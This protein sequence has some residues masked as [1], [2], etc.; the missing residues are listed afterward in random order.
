MTDPL[1]NLAQGGTG[2]DRPAGTIRRQLV[3][4][5]VRAWTD[6]LIDLSGRNGLLFYRDLPVGTLD[7]A[8][9]DPSYAE[10]LV[11]GE[12]VRLS[13]LFSADALK[14]AAKRA[15]KIRD[16]AR[17]N[18][19]ERGVDTLYLVRGMATWTPPAG[20]SAVPNAPILLAGLSLTPRGAA[21]ED[22]DLVVDAEVAV[23]PTLLYSLDAN[24]GVKVSLG[25]LAAGQADPDEGDGRLAGPAALY[26]QLEALAGAVPGFEVADRLVVGNF[27]YTKLPMVTDLQAH[28]DALAAHDLVAAIAGDRAAQTAIRSRQVSVD[29]RELDSIKLSDEFLVR[30]A[31]ASQQAAIQA[32]MA[33]SDVVIQGPPGTGKSQ[34]IANLVASLAASGRRVLFVAEKRAAIDAVIGRLDH[35]GLSDLVLDLHGGVKSRRRLAENLAEALGA[36]REAPIP[37]TEDLHYQLAARRKTLRAHDRAMNERRAP[38]GAS[39]YEA[40]ARSVG[41]DVGIR[42]APSVVETLTADRLREIKEVLRQ[43]LALGGTRIRAET[44]PWLAVGPVDQPAVEQLSD[45]VHELDRSAGPELIAAVE[46][47]RTALGT[48]QPASVQD[49]LRQITL[50][51]EL[52]KIACRLDGRRIATIAALAD[53]LEPARRGRVARFVARLTSSPYRHAL[54]SARIAVGGAPVSAEELADLAVTAAQLA[55]RWRS[56]G[57]DPASPVPVSDQGGTQAAAAFQPVMRRIAAAIPIPGPEQLSLAEM[58]SLVRG[59]VEDLPTLRRLPEIRLNQKALESAGLQSFVS[60]VKSVDLDGEAAVAALDVVWAASVIERVVARDPAIGAFDGGRLRDEAAR[61]RVLDRDHVAAAAARVKRAWA[62][63]AVAA[64]DKHED[65]NLVVSA[66]ARKKSGHLAIRD[67]FAQAPD[68]LTAVKPCWAMS[69]L[70][71]SQ[72]LPAGRAYF[73]VVIFDEASQI[74]PA[75]AIASIVRATRA[76]VAGDELQLPPTSFFASQTVA[77]RDLD[78]PLDGEGEVMTSGYQSILEVAEPLIGSAPL[79]WHYRSRDERLIAFSNLQIYRPRHRELTTFP[80]VTDVGCISHVRVRPRPGPGTGDTSTE[81]VEAV[82]RLVVA[83]AQEH[84]EQSLGVIAMGIKHADRVQEAVRQARLLRGDLESFFAESADEPFFVKNLERVQGDER[85]AIIITVGYGPGP[86]GRL[87]HQFGPINQ[88]GGERRL[89]VAITRAK[90]RLTVV[91][92]FGSEDVDPA[93]SNAEGVRLLRNY[94]RYAESGGS[95][96]GDV[97]APRPELNPFERDVLLALEAEGLAVIPQ[98]GTSGYFLDFAVQH[99]QK[100]GR[101]VLAIE[102]DGATYHSAP[103]TRERDRLR[104]QQLE[105]IGWRFHRIWSPDWFRDRAG[106]I[107]RIKVAYVAALERDDEPRPLHQVPEAAPMPTM[108]PIAPTPLPA[109]RLP[110]PRVPSYYS[111]DLVPRTMID[112]VVEWIE[113]DDRLRTEDEVVIETVT[114]L[115]FERRGKKIVTAIEESIRR[116]R[117]RQKRRIRR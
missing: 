73:D 77:D 95:D 14:D 101:F 86:D 57:G 69:P 55:D 81:E 6:Q 85:D 43:F 74:P 88:Q 16:K 60:A 75:D 40:Q 80:A 51:D 61:Y 18:L 37:N 38:W 65:Q 28:V 52:D 116:L 97:V 99:P 1:P 11:A 68:V 34:T 107:G 9:A 113:S 106:E 111:I 83:H 7:L 31:D 46:R 117:A 93:R 32:V 41:R 54:L 110:K 104:Q 82:V 115:G 53:T 10:Q 72:I 3:E 35:V 98:L 71:V 102:C 59:L 66:Q 78:E 29:E 70:L 4:R 5:A 79:R 20:S 26:R 67:L 62:E 8:D 24:F 50:L 87:R 21:G 89:N 44:N 90:E 17:E 36:A 19:E 13:S 114:A 96:L 92:S 84:P 47:T 25:F 49:A 27:S 109:R 105:A 45:A 23:S 112:R 76:V 12:R 100:P 48:E 42:L 58:Q 91:S 39:L 56:V 63:R 33:G 103:T 22:F 30:D 15:R 94:L 64:R 108:P 2:D